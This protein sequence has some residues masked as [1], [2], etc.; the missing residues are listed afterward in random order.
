MQI[1][2]FDFLHQLIPN[3]LHLTSK[4]VEVA[5][6]TYLKLDVFWIYMLVSEISNQK[7]CTHFWVNKSLSMMWDPNQRA[8]S[9]V[10]TLSYHCVCETW[11][12]FTPQPPTVVEKH[13]VRKCTNLEQNSHLLP[14][15][16]G[17]ASTNA[18]F[19][20][21]WQENGTIFLI[22]CGCFCLFAEI[23]T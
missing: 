8:S 18:S 7:F 4:L 5:T 10:S 2:N 20:L 19:L 6:A 16:R 21:P 14:V 3:S 15:R 23:V 11:C 9:G 1:S 22:C 13:N 12:N 17:A